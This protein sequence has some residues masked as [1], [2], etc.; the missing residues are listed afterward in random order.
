MASS[1]DPKPSK[2]RT[3]RKRQPPLAP[4]PPIQFVVAT[5]PNEFKDQTTMRHVRSHVMYNH[6][7]QRDSS[8]MENRRSREGSSTP[9]ITPRI[10]DPSTSRSGHIM[11]DNTYLSPDSTGSSSA[12]W[13]GNVYDYALGSHSVDPM[14]TL[15]ARIVSATTTALNRNAPPF[16]EGATHFAFAE[17]N[18]MPQEVLGNLKQEY[19]N[20][21][22]FFCHGMAQYKSSHRTTLTSLQIYRGCTTCA[23]TDFHSSVT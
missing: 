12:T 20:S 18:T 10:P 19:I 22:L 1:S 21:T 23:T 9:A 3:G 16:F 14:R 5:H 6:Q 7:E 8:P 2:K 15:A 4:G 13:S 11:E 17:H